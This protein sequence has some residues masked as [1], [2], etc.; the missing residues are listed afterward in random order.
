MAHGYSRMWTGSSFLVSSTYTIFRDICPD[1]G[2]G[3]C[4]RLRFDE[5]MKR[6]ENRRLGKGLNTNSS[7]PIET[8]LPFLPLF[9]KL[10]I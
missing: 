2:R 4:A 3:H 10:G 5:K 8:W 7:I 6:K 9:Q 1:S